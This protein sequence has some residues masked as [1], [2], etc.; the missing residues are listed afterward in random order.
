M[1]CLNLSSMC[2][3]LIR[4]QF[5]FHSQAPVFTF[6]NRSAPHLPGESSID[7]GHLDEAGR[8]TEATYGKTRLHNS[9]R[10]WWLASPLQT[11]VRLESQ[12]TKEFEKEGSGNGP[13]N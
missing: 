12:K 11:N 4:Q 3:D 7:E 6:G 8:S 10:W 5:A 1:S 9:V 13:H 2:Y